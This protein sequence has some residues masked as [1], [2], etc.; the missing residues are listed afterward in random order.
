[1]AHKASTASEKSP[2]ELQA[3]KKHMVP[4][5]LSPT[6]LDANRSYIPNKLFLSPTASC[7]LRCDHPARSHLLL[8][9]TF[10]FLCTPPLSSFTVV[11]TVLIYHVLHGWLLVRCHRVVNKGAVCRRLLRCGSCCSHTLHPVFAHT[12]RPVLA[13]IAPCVSHSLPLCSPTHR[14]YLSKEPDFF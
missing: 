14:A 6:R 7:T 8:S 11:K 1:M 9:L 13:F 2:R 5:F 12:L 3:S 4:L 10:P